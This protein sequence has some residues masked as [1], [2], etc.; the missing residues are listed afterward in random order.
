MLNF[1]V[2]TIAL[3]IKPIKPLQF[4]KTKVILT[5]SRC[6][7]IYNL[8]RDFKIILIMP[9]SIVTTEDLIELK[10]EILKEIRKMLSENSGPITKKWMKS[11]EVM[12]LLKISPGTL[13]NFRI[14]GTIPYSKIGGIIYYDAEEIQKIL[15]NNKVTF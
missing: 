1:D 8:Q 14:N 11:I 10:V 12:K 5:Q 9:A 13:Q 2:T 4:C 6:F 15:Q 3:G 7:K